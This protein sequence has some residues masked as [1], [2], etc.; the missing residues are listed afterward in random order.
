M[1]TPAKYS[2]YRPH[3]P[4]DTAFDGALVDEAT[5]EVTYPP[6]MTKQSHMAECDINNIV[7]HF[8]HTG[9]VKHMSANAAQ[10]IYTDLPNELDY[11]Q[12]LNVVLEAERAF[13]SLPSGIR[14]RFSNDPAAFLEFVSNPANADELVQLGLAVKPQAPAENTPPAT[15]ADPPAGAGGTGG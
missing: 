8:Q 15:P 4:D 13:E 14:N 6:S 1:D 7:A 5:G 9:M 3:D 10:G 12:S 2:F 11:Q